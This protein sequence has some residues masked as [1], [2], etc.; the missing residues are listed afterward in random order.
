MRAAVI[1]VLVAACSTGEPGPG[2]DVDQVMVHVG[3]LMVLGPR[4]GESSHAREAAAYIEKMV[5]AMSQKIERYPAH[6][7]RITTVRNLGYRFEN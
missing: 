6:P 5:T 2:V 3:S 1:L 7:Q 4:P